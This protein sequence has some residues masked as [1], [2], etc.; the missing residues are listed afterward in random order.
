MKKVVLTFA[1]LLTV[2]FAFAGNEIESISD[3][4]SIDISL[5][6]NEIEKPDELFYVEITYTD[7]FDY[8]IKKLEADELKYGD[9]DDGNGASLMN[10]YYY[11]CWRGWAE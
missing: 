4:F 3:S 10:W 6:E 11:W 7:C 1:L 2:S 5:V 8:A 9:I